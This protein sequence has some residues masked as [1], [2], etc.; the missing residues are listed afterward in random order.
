MPV[1][2]VENGVKV[3]AGS[4]RQS[5]D[6]LIWATGAAPW[7]WLRG[8]GLALDEKG[9]VRVKETLRSVSHPEI[10]AAGDCA[11]LDPKSGVYSVRMGELLG[12]NL[13]HPVREEALQA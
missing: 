11:A 3:V 12:E 7:P 10:F 5:F 2:G 8:S 9:F 4:A 13:R 6:R 1:M